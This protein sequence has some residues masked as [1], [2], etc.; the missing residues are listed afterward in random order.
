MGYANDTYPAMLSSEEIVVPPKKLETLFG[1]RD[2]VTEQ[3]VIFKI[4]GR[5]LEGVLFSQGKL[6]KAY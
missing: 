5:E 2:G 1:G 4:K 6:N 3:K